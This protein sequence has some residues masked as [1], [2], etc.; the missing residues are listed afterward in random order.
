[1][2]LYK[3]IIIIITGILIINLLFINSHCILKADK[4]ETA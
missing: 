1:M 3:F 2:A 4:Y